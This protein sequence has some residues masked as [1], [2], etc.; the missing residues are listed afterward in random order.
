MVDYIE[1]KGE[2]SELAGAQAGGNRSI[3]VNMIRFVHAF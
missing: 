1:A 3:T 2:H